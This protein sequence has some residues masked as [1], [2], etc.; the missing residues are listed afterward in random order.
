MFDQKKAIW[1]AMHN[2]GIE[3]PELAKKLGVST[4]MVSAWKHAYR[5]GITLKT[6]CK[7][8]EACGLKLSEFIALGE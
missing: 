2:A 4:A 7:I 3:Q 8:S 6:A 5:G 1:L